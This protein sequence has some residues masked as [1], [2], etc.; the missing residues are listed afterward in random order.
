[1]VATGLAKPISR[2]KNSQMTG[3]QVRT[4]TVRQSHDGPMGLFFGR[5]KPQ[6][7]DFL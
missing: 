2:L 5:Q 1:M 6:T 3:E 7:P 4:K